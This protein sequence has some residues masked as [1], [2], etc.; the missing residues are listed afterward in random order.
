MLLALCALAARTFWPV[1]AHRRTYLVWG[2]VPLVVWMLVFAFVANFAS[3]GNPTPLPFVP[4]LNPLDLTLGLVAMSLAQW[5]LALRRDGVLLRTAVPREALFGIP[6][7]LV[8]VWANA[9]VLRTVHHWY[10]VPWTLDGLWQSTLVQAVLSLLWSAIALATMVY[11]NRSGART[12]WIAGATLLGVVVIKLF[13]VD[14]SRVAG[15][16]RIVSFIGVG[17]LLLLIGYLAP[18]PPRRKEEAS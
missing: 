7:A 11:A 1:G 5:V 16:E 10:G 13:A 6:A 9:L 12:A 14:L 15:I 18:V 17:A 4:V 2:A 8:F 3:D